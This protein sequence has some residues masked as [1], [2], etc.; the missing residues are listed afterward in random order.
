MCLKASIRIHADNDVVHH[1]IHF[2]ILKYG[3]K[4]KFQVYES[5]ATQ[6][7]TPKMLLT[8]AYVLIYS[9]HGS[10]ALIYSVAFVIVVI[11]FHAALKTTRR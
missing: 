5:V 9:V 6:N 10:T 11:V 4:L 7:Q 8:L 1:E 3:I 2:F